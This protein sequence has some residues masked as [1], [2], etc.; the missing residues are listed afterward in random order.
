MKN[1]RFLIAA[2]A[3][4]IGYLGWTGAWAEEAAGD[5]AAATPTAVTTPSGGGEAQPAPALTSF[6]GVEGL[7]NRFA[8]MTIAISFDHLV[9]QRQE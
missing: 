4:L 6:A 9:G 1:Q 7:N 8:G 5:K 2:V 3:F